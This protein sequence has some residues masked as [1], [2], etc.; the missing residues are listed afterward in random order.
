M[1]VLTPQHEFVGPALLS[2]TEFRK[3]I[4][5]SPNTPRNWRKTGKGPKFLRIGW[6][7]YYRPSDIEAWLRSCEV[8]PSKLAV[9]ATA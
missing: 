7:Y 1:N 2:E 5:C 8:M 4:K 9:E 3:A 6:R